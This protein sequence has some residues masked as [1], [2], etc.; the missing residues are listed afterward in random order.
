[1]NYRK[2]DNRRKKRRYV[3]HLQAAGLLIQKL[4]QLREGEWRYMKREY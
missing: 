4:S 2:Y 3:K 1:M